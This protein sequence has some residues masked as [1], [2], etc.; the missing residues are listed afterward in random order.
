VRRVEELCHSGGGETGE[1]APAGPDSYEIALLAAGG[2]LAAIDAAVAGTA[3]RVFANVR[4]PG[5]HAVAA[6][7]MGYCIF[8]NVAI[9]ARHAQRAHGLKKILI[10]D[11]DVHHGNGTQAAFYGDPDVLFVSLHQED[12]YPRESGRVDQCGEGAGLGFTVNLPLPPGTGN[13]GYLAAF[14][15][16]IVPIADTFRPELV[17]VSAGQDASLMDQLGRMCVST[18]GYRQ[19]TAAV[20]GIAERHAGGRVVVL[21]EGGYSEL[22]SPYCSLA[23]VETL[24]RTR[25]GVPEPQAVDY[26][27]TMPYAQRVGLDCEAALAAI[28]AQQAAFWPVLRKVDSPASGGDGDGKRAH[29]QW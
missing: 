29:V 5:H 24:A 8:N 21:Q 9:A 10:V 25:T 22:Y 23:I 26:L 27:E 2:G 13:R 3:R 20:I 7:G 1:G 11:W 4:P 19:M 12:L 6:K 18:E 14:E 17:L 28:V 15:R 16:V